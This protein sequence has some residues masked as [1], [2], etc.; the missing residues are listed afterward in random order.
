MKLW[1]LLFACFL[2]LF[3]SLVALWWR[4]V[5]ARQ[6]QRMAGA[7]R[8]GLAPPE[9]IAT[10]VILVEPPTQTRGLGKFF[11]PGAGANEE[12]A[13]T[14]KRQLA[15][16][17][18]V[19]ALAGFLLGTR[20]VSLIGPAAP[21]IGGIVCGAV[22]RMMRKKK[23]GQRLGMLEQQFPEALDCLARS[24]RAG[25]AFSVAIELLAGE[26]GDPLKAEFQKISRELALGAGL[27]DALQGLIARVPLME[28]RFFVSAVLLQR[29]TGGNL[30]EVVG[31]LSDSLRERFKLR[32]H[33][34]ASSGQGRL[35]AGVLSVLPVIIVVLLSMFSP[36]YMRNLTDDP[37]GRDLLGAAVVF[38]IIGYVV[39]T[40]ITHIEV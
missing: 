8:A 13:E 26:I 22:P 32:G 6:R 2:S 7:V 36:D 38:Q 17:T 24:L 15:I 20:F 34:K 28:V 37:I 21:L 3:E 5:N 30:S 35:T 11:K 4:A 40:R 25:N 18:M 19:G 10:P 16:M 27:E 31:K 9:G 33:V 39:M 1:L 23:Q 14:S 29:E 12:N